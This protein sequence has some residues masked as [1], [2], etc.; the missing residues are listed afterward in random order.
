MSFNEL[1]QKLSQG[2]QNLSK[3]CREKYENKAESGKQRYNA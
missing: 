1:S 3:P 2:W